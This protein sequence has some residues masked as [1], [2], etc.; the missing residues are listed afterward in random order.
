MNEKI[1]FFHN[2]KAGGTSLA[3]LIRRTC[4]SENWC[5]TIENDAVQHNALSGNYSQYRG[6]QVY[7]GH[8]GYDIFSAVNDNHKYTTNFRHPVARVL[9]LYNYFRFVVSLTEEELCNERFVAVRL[10]KNA[11]F[12]EFVLSADPQV[13]VYI[14][15]AHFRQLTNTCWSL[16]STATL[17]DAHRFIDKMPCYFVCE[18][19]E[20]S[21]LWI[22]RTFRWG[23]VR[24]SRENVTDDQAGNALH[25]SN[26]DEKTIE[27]ILEKNQLDTAI[28]RFAVNRL[29]STP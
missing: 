5:P 28:Y 22:N 15:N 10:S 20:L 18:Y 14:R 12:H 17:L 27:V 6:Y 11:D 25:L 9:S 23:Q 13:E 4:P 3:H 1:F 21:N 7:A 26:L 16:D 19:P 24:M 29:L 8:Y 2:P